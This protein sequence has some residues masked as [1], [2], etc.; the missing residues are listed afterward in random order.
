MSL[1]I[2]YPP[3][4]SYFRLSIIFLTPQILRHL[5]LRH[6]LLWPLRDHHWLYPIP[7]DPVP[8]WRPPIWPT[9]HIVTFSFLSLFSFTQCILSW[10]D[11]SQVVTPCDQDL[12]IHFTTH[13]PCACFT[14]CLY[15]R[16]LYLLRKRRRFSPEL[17][18]KFILSHRFASLHL[19]TFAPL[20]YLVLLTPFA[21]LH[22]TEPPSCTTSHSLILHQETISLLQNCTPQ[23]HI[24]YTL[25]SPSP[26]IFVAS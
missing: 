14:Y 22:H 20:L 12:T 13:E 1:P 25:R 26:L 19:H 16:L 4:A 23:N 3:M 24:G 21:L 18:L 9:D 8:R 11:R 15:L 17:W 10:P 2:R 7:I 5:P 6:D